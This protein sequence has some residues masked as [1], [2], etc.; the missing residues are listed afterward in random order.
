MQLNFRPFYQSIPEIYL[1]LSVVF[2]L[3]WIAGFVVPLV[4]P[5]PAELNPDGVLAVLVVM[6]VTVLMTLWGIFGLLLCWRLRMPLLEVS[7]VL[8]PCCSV[9]G[10]AVWGAE[11]HMVFLGVGLYSSI[12]LFVWIVCVMRVF[13]PVE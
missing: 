1:V 10:L 9:F 6:A 13:R 7:V 4:S 12:F 3:F 2:L 8:C 5:Y 11:Y